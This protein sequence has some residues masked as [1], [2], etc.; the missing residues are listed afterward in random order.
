MESLENTPAIDLETKSRKEYLEQIAGNMEE[1][2]LFLMQELQAA[3]L[4]EVDGRIRILDCGIGGGELIEYLKEEYKDP[5]VDI[6]ALDIIHEYVNRVKHESQSKVFAVVGDALEPPFNTESL[7]AV[8]LSSVL[9]EIISYGSNLEKEN[10]FS[11]TQKL[12]SKLSKCLAHGGIFSYRDIYLPDNHNEKKSAV[13]SGHF[14]SFIF[15]FGNQILQNTRKV[16]GTDLPTILNKK[17]SC[18]I[19]GNIHYHRELQR[20]FVTFTDFLCTYNNMTS[21]KATLLK[22]SGPDEIDSLFSRSFLHERL[23]DDWGKREG[24]E[25]YTYASV[26]E[27]KEILNEVSKENDFELKVEQIM[28]P[29]RVEYSNFLDQYTDFS[30]PDKKRMMLI[31]KK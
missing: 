11:V 3:R 12:F 30:I 27:I 22:K 31:R 23:L 6:I 21:L 1:K 10:R 14:S 13:Y 8:N 20:H 15:M 2:S 25:T 28:F 24:F 18:E 9:H 7:S 19:S 26:G 29:E 17:G 16:F 5:F 4:P